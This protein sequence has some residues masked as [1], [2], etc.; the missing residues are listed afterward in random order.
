MRVF[1]LVVALLSVSSP[2]QDTDPTDRLF[3]D[4]DSENF[5]VREAAARAIIQLG[6]SVRPR[7]ESAI[8]FGTPHAAIHLRTILE[9]INWPVDVLPKELATVLSKH[10]G[11][12]HQ[13]VRHTGKQVYLR[14]LNKEWS[15][16]K[17][18]LD[19]AGYR[20]ISQRDAQEGSTHYTECTYLVKASAWQPGDGVSFD[21]RLHFRADATVSADSATRYTV[22][23]AEARWHATFFRPYREVSFPKGTLLQTMIEHERFVQ[24]GTSYPILNEIEFWYVLGRSEPWRDS[25]SSVWRFYLIPS[26]S[27]K[28]GLRDSRPFFLAVSHL[29][30][31]VWDDG[32]QR[33]IGWVSKE[34]VGPIQSMGGSTSDRT[35]SGLHILY[36]PTWK[37]PWD[38]DK[39]KEFRAFSA[40]DLK[41]LSPDTATLYIDVPGVVPSD[42]EALVTLPRLTRV[43]LSCTRISVGTLRKLAMIKSLTGLDLD[44]EQPLTEDVIRFV[45]SM[46]LTS[47]H[48][49]SRCDLSDEGL[50]VLTSNRSLRKLTISDPQSTLSNMGLKSLARLPLLHTLELWYSDRITNE[51]LSTLA[52]H[53]SL[54]HLELAYLGS[55]NDE[56]LK[57]LASSPRLESLDLIKLPISD[58]GLNHFRAMKSL[59]YLRLSQ[60]RSITSEG[61]K[62][63]A[64]DHP[65]G[66]RLGRE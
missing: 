48:S 25:T 33:D 32:V 20:S 13:L 56:G 54:R 22:T 62:N 34:S 45:A 64:A 23:T 44:P 3:R 26:L 47:I 65:N 9:S 21:L 37:A 36:D 41:A 53:P 16:V 66:L 60:C 50:E 7:I 18:V 6:T 28:D 55:L 27:T 11:D 58:E 17:R 43:W 4:L 38:H 29:D 57:V 49:G 5:E 39:P 31:L 1:V 51:G 63:L 40:K 30:D 59:R 46:G 24:D 14:C 12:L 2:F 15:T 52:T 42:L 61:V 10:S 8:K 19:A 35:G